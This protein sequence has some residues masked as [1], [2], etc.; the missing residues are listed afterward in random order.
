MANYNNPREL[1]EVFKKQ[2]ESDPFNNLPNK[3][4]PL[5]DYDA[6]IDG[7]L[8]GFDPQLLEGVEPSDFGQGFIDDAENSYHAAP[9]GY[10]LPTEHHDYIKNKVDELIG[11]KYSYLKPYYKRG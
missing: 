5:S 9:V 10:K 7:W 4:T 3:D 2:M 1:A 11:S 8:N 6:A